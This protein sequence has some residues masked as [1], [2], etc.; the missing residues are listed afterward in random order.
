VDKASP[1]RF[2]KK[3]KTRSAEPY[4]EGS[5]STKRPRMSVS[6]GISKG[7]SKTREDEHL[8]KIFRGRIPDPYFYRVIGECYVHGMMDGEAIFYQ[9]HHRRD[10]DQRMESQVFELR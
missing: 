9:E 4:T 7:P 2:G 3:R 6:R 1:G 5:P 8:D 10:P